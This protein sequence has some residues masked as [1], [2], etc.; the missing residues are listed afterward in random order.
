MVDDLRKQKS[1]I[2]SNS[3]KEIYEHF[4]SSAN[5]VQQI[6]IVLDNAGFELLGDLCFVEMLYQTGLLDEN[7][8][9]IFHDKLFGWFVRYDD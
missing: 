9:I 1:K 4:R 8:K 3:T 7:S 5:K 6:T 2:V